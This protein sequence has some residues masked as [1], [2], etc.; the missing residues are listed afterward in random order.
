MRL[1]FIKPKEIGDSLILTPT[2]KAAKQAYPESEIW[3]MVRRGCEG[4]LA[5]C[6]EIDRLVAL[7]GVERKERTS[8]DIWKDLQVLRRLRSVH[9]DLVFELS[10]G[11]RG[12]LFAILTQADSRYTVKLNGPL[13]R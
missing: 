13:K 7:S 8:R 6:P 2:L 12:R 9:F 10:D 5:G 3:V 1:L 4:I 11:H